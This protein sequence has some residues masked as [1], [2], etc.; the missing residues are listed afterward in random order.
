MVIITGNVTK[1]HLG[2]PEVRRKKQIT[3]KHA[4]TQK[5]YSRDLYSPQAFPVTPR[6]L[7]IL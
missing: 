3:N 6:F 2:G 1:I 5:K 7:G 4:K